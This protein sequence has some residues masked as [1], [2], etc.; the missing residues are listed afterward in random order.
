MFGLMDRYS[1]IKIRGDDMGKV[2]ANKQGDC[3]KCKTKFYEGDIIHVEKGKPPLCEKCGPKDTGGATGTK[4]TN[5]WDIFAAA[6]LA[7]PDM[8]AL[9]STDDVTEIAM[10][11]ADKMM[12][13]RHKRGIK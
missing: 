10:K 9:K 6:A 8:R 2:K 5:P 3:S 4:T 7:N 1:G 13:G 11:I 12:I